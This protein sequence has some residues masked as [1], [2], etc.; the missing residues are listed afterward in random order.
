MMILTCGT[1]YVDG[2]DDNEDEYGNH[3][4]MMK[5]NNKNNTDTTLT[6]I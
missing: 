4:T 2:Y 6:K 1:H 5:R 3:G